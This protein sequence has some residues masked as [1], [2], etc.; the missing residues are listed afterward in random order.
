MKKLLT[1]ALA[2]VVLTTF[3][4]LATAATTVK[5]SKSN[6]SEREEN[7][8]A[9][10]KLMTGKVTAV[11]NKAKTFTVLTKGKAVDVSG[12]KLK[13]LPNVGEIVDITYTET[14]GGGLVGATTV[15]NSKSNH[16]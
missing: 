5:G 12:A 6:G 15:N 4:G 16:F 14:L 11:N 3:S 10:P 7:D 13:T 1:L 8:K 2:I 9:T